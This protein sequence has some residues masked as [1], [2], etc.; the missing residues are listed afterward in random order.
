MHRYDE[1]E[2]NM[3]ADSA[4]A[5][6][7]ETLRTEQAAQAVV[8]AFQAGDIDTLLAHYPTDEEGFTYVDMWEPETVR[9]THGELIQ[10][11]EDFGA[12][13]DT[14]SGGLEVVSLTAQ[15][16][17]AVVELRIT[18]RYVGE[19]APAD[20]AAMEIRSCVVFRR[21]EDGLVREERV[22]AEAIEAQI[23]RALGQ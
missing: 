11:M 17:R 18:G 23:A 6:V 15:G 3:S 4:H 10:W 22:Y 19:G 21:L 7:D 5:A 2:T 12:V 8:D 16:T 20:G 13:F 9:R 14:S 1:K